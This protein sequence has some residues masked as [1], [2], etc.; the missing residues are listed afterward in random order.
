MTDLI[1]TP[2]PEQWE[3]LTGKALLASKS[4]WGTIAGGLVGWLAAHYG[5]GWDQTTC[6]LIA[7]GGVI[8]A[9]YA[10]RWLTTQP[11]TGIF[12]AKPL[13]VRHVE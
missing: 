4:P 5:L 3:V 10:M 1:P 8:L 7:G 6:N 9:S 12:T 2:A 13:L 11:I